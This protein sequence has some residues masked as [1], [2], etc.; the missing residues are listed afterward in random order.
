MNKTIIIVVIAIIVIL[1]GTGV[2]FIFGKSKTQ[3]SS[4][5]TPTQVQAGWQEKGVAVAG[6]YAD[7]D[8]VALDDG[9]YRMYYATEPEVV[10][11]KL[12]VF[13]ATSK[14]GQ[15]WQQEEGI[16]KQFAV[17][18][19][20]I[21]LPSGKWRMY[22]QNDRVIKSALSDDGL[23]W[24]DEPGTRID[25]AETGFN[26]ENVAAPST[27]KLDNGQYI[28]VYRGSENKLYGT[29][30]LPNQTTSYFFYALSDDG[31]TFSKKDIALDSRNETLKG[32]VDGPD[33]VKWD[34]IWRLYFWS[35]KGVYHI[36][37]QNGQFSREPVF[38]FTN[39]DASAEPFPAN[40]PADP[41][42]IKIGLDWFMYYGQHTKGIFYAVL[43]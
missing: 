35:Y 23:T 25:A 13:S 41:S 24:T 5:T 6:K 30:K 29:E 15:T 27:T 32:S 21:K 20:V 36:T 34:D 4:S 43:E 33:W 22:Y 40:P 42:V 10:N 39:K 3:P 14:D 17:F 31:L 16:R 28:M 1:G 12:E 11:N 18:P 19:D 9:S 2:Y 26:L 8:V 38:D 37:Y 7:A